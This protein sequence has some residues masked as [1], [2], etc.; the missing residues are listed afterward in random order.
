MTRRA[1]QFAVIAALAVAVPLLADD[2]NSGQQT[3]V[4]SETHLPGVFDV[5]PP[6]RTMKPS[7]RVD[8]LR[9]YGPLATTPGE[10]TKDHGNDAVSETPSTPSMSGKLRARADAGPTWLNSTTFQAQGV[11]FPGGGY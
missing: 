2:N 6:L 5:S 11:T 7:G 1:V 3:F 10:T 8:I 4:S 9:M